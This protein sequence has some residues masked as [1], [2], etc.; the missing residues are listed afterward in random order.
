MLGSGIT[1]FRGLR[2]NASSGTAKDK[3][4][5]A[6]N[7]TLNCSYLA[8]YYFHVMLKLLC[9]TTVHYYHKYSPLAS[10]GLNT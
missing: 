9:A 4:V 5:V 2:F 8:L 1:L 6:L 3:D 7:V 10:L